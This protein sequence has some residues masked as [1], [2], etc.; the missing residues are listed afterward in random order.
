MTFV[1][2]PAIVTLFCVFTWP[3]KV[4]KTRTTRALCERTLLAPINS[5]RTS[6]PPANDSSDLLYN[7]H[8]FPVGRYNLSVVTILPGEKK[9]RR[10]RLNEDVPLTPV[11]FCIIFQSILWPTLFSIEVCEAVS[12]VHVKV[13]VGVV[14][15]CQWQP[16]GR[17][18]RAC[19]RR[20]KIW[21]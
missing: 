18:W 19:G 11:G 9:Q 14:S 12:I 15:C 16:T 8:R 7:S 3:R 4:A 10:L 2:F 17:E 21:P 13:V 20:S 1:P 5:S 6:S